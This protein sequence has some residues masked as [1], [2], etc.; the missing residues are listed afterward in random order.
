[1]ARELED[2]YAAYNKKYFGG[3]LPDVSVR[4]C[5]RSWA[6]GMYAK[7]AYHIDTIKSSDF[8]AT[9]FIAR[10]IKDKRAVWHQTLLHECIHVKLRRYLETESHHGWRFR[11]E[12]DRL[13]RLGALDDLF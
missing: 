4:W 11:K 7:L 10:E 1:V 8:K 12:R 6:A 5:H 9:I 13:V 2:Q 3:R